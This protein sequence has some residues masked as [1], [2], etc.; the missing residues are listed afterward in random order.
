MF[1]GEICLIDKDG[2]E[3]FQSVMKQLRRKD[4]QIENPEFRMFD[5]IHKLDFEAGKQRFD[6]ILS[7]RLRTLRS[8]MNNNGYYDP[9]LCDFPKPYLRYL[10]QYLIKG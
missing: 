8:F 2:N 5:M 6:G 3:D 7:D 9:D 1:D 10:D 4:H